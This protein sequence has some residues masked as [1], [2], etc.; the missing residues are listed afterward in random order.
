MTATLKTP[1]RQQGA[2]LRLRNG[3]SGVIECAGETLV[4]LLIGT[5]PIGAFNVIAKTWVEEAA[6]DSGTDVFL[7]GHKRVAGADDDFF[8][9]AGDVDEQTPAWYTDMVAARASDTPY[10]AAT[11]VYMKYSGQNGDATT[12]RI[13]T[14]LTWDEFNAHNA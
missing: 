2:G 9:D 13:H 8:Q 11:P 7:V 5:I 14:Y 6:N 3:C 10:T 4:E 1:Q 12:G